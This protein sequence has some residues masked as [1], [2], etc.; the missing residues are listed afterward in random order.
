PVARQAHN[1]KVVGSNP[2]PATK[3]YTKTTALLGGSY[4]ANGIQPAV[5]ATAKVPLV[6][7]AHVPAK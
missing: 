1:L 3:H 2:T 5:C 4:A 7:Y 6:F